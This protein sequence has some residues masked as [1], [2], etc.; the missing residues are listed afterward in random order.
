MKA[1]I[2]D[3]K[4][5]KKVTVKKGTPQEKETY[6]FDVSYNQKLGQFFSDS[7]QQN[8]FIKGQEVEFTEVEKL[9]NGNPIYY[10]YPVK[11]SAKSGYSK[12]LQKEQSR[13]SGFAVSYVKDLI[14]AGKID[15]SK[16][17]QESERIFNFM[18]KL[19]KS[20]NQ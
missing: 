17:E 11:K 10:L 9:Y 2:D 20:L 13:Y 16:W 18:V 4:F 3:V 15:Y 5:N 19:D 7:E 1:I 14:I 8:L 6:M 12:A